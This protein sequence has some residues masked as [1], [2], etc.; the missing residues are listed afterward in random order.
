MTVA[1]TL[2]A[3]QYISTG[4]NTQFAYPNKVFSATDLLV[5]IFD[6]LGNAYPFVN[7]V[8]VGLGLTFSVQNVDVDTGCT[9][10]LSAPFTTGW[11]V[12]IRTQTAPIQSTSVKNQGQFLPEL[13]EEA[14][15]RL[16]RMAQDLMRLSYTYGIHGPDTEV[17]PWPALPV[18]SLRK[19]YGL[20]FDAVTGL[21]GLGF[22]SAQNVTFGLLAP[23]LNLQQTSAEIAAGVTPANS[24]YPP[25]SFSRYGVSTANADNGP[26]INN[27][28][29]C[30]SVVY[31][32]NMSGPSTY[33]VQTTIRFR[34]AGQV[35]RGA[36]MGD[37]NTAGG[38]GVKF[39]PRTTLKWTGATGAA[40]VSFSDQVTNWSQ[41]TLQDISIDG[42]ANLARY[43]VAYDDAVPGGCWRN[44]L[45]NVTITNCTNGVQP[46]AVYL[47]A[48][49]A[50]G[51]ANDTILENC[52][53]WAS[54]IGVFN[55]GAVPQL[56]RC[57]VGLMTIAGLFMPGNGSETKVYGG[58]FHNNVV[59]I[60]VG[61]TGVVQN[62]SCFGTWFENSATGIFKAHNSFSLMLEGCHLHTD[63]T[64][65]TSMMDFN[66]Q[67]GH[68]AIKSWAAPGAGTYL[69][70]NTN[71]VYDYDFISSGLVTD[72]GYKLRIAG[73]TRIDNAKFSAGVTTS[74]VNSTGDGTLFSLNATP[75]TVGTDLSPAV[76][77]ATGV[78]TAPADGYYRFNAKLE[79]TGIAAGHTDAQLSLVV[80]GTSAQTYLLTR[81]NPG[82]QPVAGGS[83]VNIQGHLTVPMTKNDTAYLTILVSG[84][85]K[86]VGVLSGVS[87]TNY[88]TLF[89]GQAT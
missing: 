27:A 15:D 78:F 58:V 65:V 24:S 10:V 28:L 60:D 56:I 80:T 81:M 5:T 64:N 50:S 7:F 29:K 70:A 71:P 44:I 31:D 4:V 89:Q 23:L 86:V 52:Y 12:D 39:A 68:V 59:D 17:A 85:T 55:N 18:P 87:G 19:G 66:A 63:I 11:T 13:H 25:G 6:L 53:L 88:R 82:A 33:P 74:T 14:F 47:G 48:A 62:V 45:R 46:S 75:V 72:K 51:F 37:N 1:S 73:L 49:G 2:T 21:P 8:N 77:A 57:T 40:V 76:N 61:S 26:N 41:T 16:T 35:L 22:L 79:L 84:S 30:N 9:V 54:G 36:G 43:G 83:E 34:S 32:D 42:G 67:A 3:K 69:I 38:A 20:L